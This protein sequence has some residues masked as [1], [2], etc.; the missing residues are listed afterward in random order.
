MSCQY[1]QK[2]GHTPFF[3]SF[4]ASSKNQV[5]LIKKTVSKD[6][7][8]WFFSFKEKRAKTVSERIFHAGE[9]SRVFVSTNLILACRAVINKKG[10]DY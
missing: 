9:N 2:K 7:R 8:A 6:E 10:G 5:R 1:N 3:L 4:K